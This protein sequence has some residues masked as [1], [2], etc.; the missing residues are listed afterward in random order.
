[1]GSGPVGVKARLAP[2]LPVPVVEKRGE[3][4]V[5]EY[6]RAKSIGKV[7]AFHGNFM[8]YVRSL[9]YAKM[10]GGD[11]LTAASKRAVLNANYMRKVLLARIPDIEMP[12]QE[13]RMHEFVVSCAPAK[14]TRGIRATDVAKRLL[15]YGYHAPTVYFPLIVDEAIMI[16]PTETES[17][18]TLDRFCDAMVHILT[19][20]DPEVV[21]AAPHNTAVARVDEVHA[22]KSPRLT[23]DMHAKDEAIGK[24]L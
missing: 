5:A 20:E 9:V 21:K 12:Y 13:L 18:E 11:G 7:K 3:K 16:E 15:D 10:M 4:Y 24:P 8:G 23:F 17:K 14:K 22:V 6:H 2:Y 1:P 19:R